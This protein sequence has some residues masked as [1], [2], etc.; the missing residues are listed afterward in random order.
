[1]P[2]FLRNALR[3]EISNHLTSAEVRLV[4]T[5]PDRNAG[6]NEDTEDAMQIRHADPSQDHARHLLLRQQTPEEIVAEAEQIERYHD[7]LLEAADD[8]EE[9]INYLD[10]LD[11]GVETPSMIAKEWGVETKMIYKLEN[12]LR[13]RVQSL[14]TMRQRAAGAIQ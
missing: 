4:D 1:M 8:D 3:S 10:A 6:D 7:L 9:L 14:V 5:W 12:R 2:T 13:K 11:R